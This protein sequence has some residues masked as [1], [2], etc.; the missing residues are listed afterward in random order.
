[1]KKPFTD[2][3]LFNMNTRED[4]VWY[5]TEGPMVNTLY[6]SVHVGKKVKSASVYMPHD[7]RAPYAAFYGT[8]AKQDTTCN[9]PGATVEQLMA[10][11]EEMVGK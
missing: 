6:V 10:W 7:G 5:R 4:G 11:C 2:Y 1:M 9:M 8:T 3:P